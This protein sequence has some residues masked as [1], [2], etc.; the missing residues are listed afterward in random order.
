MKRK[1][2]KEKNRE[3]EREGRGGEKSDENRIWVGM[4]KLFSAS[5]AAELT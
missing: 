4:P 1:L 3:K 5:V 2:G